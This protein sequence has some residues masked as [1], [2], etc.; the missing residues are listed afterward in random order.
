MEMTPEQR[1]YIGEM[2]RLQVVDRFALASVY[3]RYRN[4]YE[5]MLGAAS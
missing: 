3:R 4:L 1:E 5:G 2:A